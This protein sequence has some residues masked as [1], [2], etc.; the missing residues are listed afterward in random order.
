MSYNVIVLQFKSGNNDLQSIDREGIYSMGPTRFSYHFKGKIVTCINL[1]A[2]L[3]CLK[4]LMIA[5]FNGQLYYI[6]LEIK[7]G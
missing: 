4:F 2:S 7:K 1:K 6:F 5:I 3:S